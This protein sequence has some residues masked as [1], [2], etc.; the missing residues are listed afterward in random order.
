VLGVVL[1]RKGY[2]AVDLDRHRCIWCQAISERSHAIDSGHLPAFALLQI[3]GATKLP[4]VKM[5]AEASSAS[6]EEL[7]QEAE[8]QGRRVR[9]RPAGGAIAERAGIGSLGT[10]RGL[11]PMF[12]SVAQGRHEVGERHD[13]EVKAHQTLPRCDA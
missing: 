7:L 5:M 8:A 11:H 9:A 3:E 6:H 4:S 1:A 13:A 2:A 10:R 12:A